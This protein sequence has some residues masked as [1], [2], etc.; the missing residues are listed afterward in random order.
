MFSHTVKMAKT[1]QSCNAHC[2]PVRRTMEKLIIVGGKKVDP[3][4]L[5]GSVAV[6]KKGNIILHFS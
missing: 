5:A 2:G 6:S 3:V 4:T 1:H